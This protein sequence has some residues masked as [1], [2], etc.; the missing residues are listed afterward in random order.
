MI[1]KSWTPHE[2]LCLRQALHL[3]Q[4]QFAKRLGVSSHVVI[5]WWESGRHRPDPRAR[6]QLDALSIGIRL[7]VMT[8]TDP[9]IPDV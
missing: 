3:N 6:L 7:I 9:D 8:Q 2:I 5:S 4:D 1:E